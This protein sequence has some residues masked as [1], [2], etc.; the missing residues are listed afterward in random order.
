M[1]DVITLLAEEKSVNEYGDTTLTITERRVFVKTKSIGQ[2]EFYQSQAVGL[3]PEV[4]FVLADFLD[5]K[6]EKK[7]KYKPFGGREEIYNVIRT[8]RDGY[9]LEL[10]CNRIIE[11]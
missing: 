5:Y 9:M 7:L 3:K 1:N 4:K 2:S 11:K 10:V 8:F 6:G